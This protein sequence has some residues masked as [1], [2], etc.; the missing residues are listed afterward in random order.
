MNRLL[1]FLLLALPLAAQTAQWDSSGNTLLNGTYRFREVTWRPNPLDPSQLDE[2]SSTYGTIQ[3]DGFGNYTLFAQQFSSL[4]NQTQQILPYSGTYVISASGLG[5]IR[6]SNPNGGWIQG[7]I[8]N[9]VF[10]GS[11]TEHQTNNL[12][13]ATRV[14]GTLLT[15]AS[16]NQS[17]TLAYMDVR[18][19]SLSQIRDV[20]FAVQG[21]G[22]GGLGALNL[23][24]RIGVEFSTVNQSI[25]G[26]TY[27][28]TGSGIGTLNFNATA[29]PSTLISGSKELYA[30]PDGGFIFGGATDGWDMLV[31][32]RTP[33]APVQSSV[34]DYLYYQAG[35]EVDRGRDL[36]LFRLDSFYGAF[37]PRGSDLIGHQ[38]ILLGLGIP[39]FNFT[40]SDDVFLQPSGIQT[41]YLGYR[42]QLSADGRFRV[43]VGTGAFLGINATVKAPTL[44]GPGVFL[45]P[46]GVVNAAGFT[47]FTVGIS[48]GAVI[49]LFGTGI[50]ETVAV[51]STFPLTL[52]GLEV[53]INGKVAPI[54]KTSPGEVSVVVPYEVADGG[55]TVAEI[56]VFRNGT[57][58][59][60]VTA[61]IN[62]DTP[63]L[64]TQTMNGLGHAAA[65][66]S[67]FS[68]ITPQNPARPGEVIMLFLSGLGPTNPPVVAGTP[69]PVNPFSLTVSDFVV[70]M[71]GF[72]APIEYSGLAPFLGGLYQMNV[73]IPAQLPAGD[74]FVQIEGPST[75]TSQAKLPI[76]LPLP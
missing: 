72:I 29:G 38:R 65:L 58:G 11:S 28:F 9:D 70:K 30:S 16:F 22:L 41:D 57:P 31:G 20:M 3:F 44:S 75:I 4:T 76:G 23:T 26:S 21:D 25:T 36:T 52:N 74:V 13:I 32:V 68:L 39:P 1:P 67:D 53:K 27:S 34:F 8:S 59:N 43:G 45:N 7:A 19:P 61:Y 18:L 14:G 73:K 10:I 56:Q 48:P 60:R 62:N 71:S 64:F 6:R 17:Y 24:G 37:T 46:V 40:Y 12:F 47:P 5:F 35:M 15:T 49:T 42:H 33:T 66:H 2:A 63:S 54:Y 50:A 69:A 55:E 51:D